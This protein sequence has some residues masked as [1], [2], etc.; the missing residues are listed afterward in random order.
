MKS[1]TKILLL[2]I[3]SSYCNDL[4][5]YCFGDFIFWSG[6]KL[7]SLLAWVMLILSFR[8]V[9]YLLLL[10]QQTYEI[11]LLVTIEL[12][13]VHNC[14]QKHEMNFNT[15]LFKGKTSVR[16]LLEMGIQ[17][18]PFLPFNA[19]AFYFCD[20]SNWTPCNRAIVAW[21]WYHNSIRFLSW[22]VQRKENIGTLYG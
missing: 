3:S 7:P 16:I 12:K 22:K 21:F 13:P 6:Y 17:S 8:F 11:V 2:E 9:L 5:G 14:K 4:C 10:M 15:V 1:S 18:V 20:F 19:P